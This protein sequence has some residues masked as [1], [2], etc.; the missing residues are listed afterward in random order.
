MRKSLMLVLVLLA[1]GVWAQDV[2]KAWEGTMTVPTYAWHD[3][4][5][6]VF[7]PLESA[8]Y[9]PYSKQDVIA[10]TKTDRVYR[11]LFLE[12]EYLKV[13]CLPELGGRI[14]SVLDKTTNREMF[15]KNDEVKP[16]LIAMRGAWISG[17]IEWNPGPQGH[18]V[19][20]VSP[21]DATLESNPDGSQSL[22]VS[23]TEKMFRTQWSVRL[24][25]HPGKAFLDE[26]IRIFNPTD[27]THPYYFWNCTAFPNRP[28]TRFIYPMTLGTDHAGSTFYSWP[29][30]KDRDLSWLKNYP[31]MSSIFGYKCEFDFFGA[32]DVDLDQGLISYA[33]HYVLPGKK[34]WTWG[35]D[36][37]GV[38]SQMELSD[39]GREGAPY[40]EVQSGPLRTQA[41][42][43][44]LHPHKQVAWKEFWYPVHSLGDGFEF[45]TC[46]AAVQTH[47]DDAGMLEFRIIATGAYPNTA[48]VLSL[49]GKTVLEKTL[50]LSPLQP[51]VVTLPAAAKEK[52]KITL[53]TSDNETLL[54]Y[55]T[56]LDIPKV[57]APD[58]AE[59]PARSDGQP[60]AEEKFKGAWLLDSQS[61]RNGAR[62]AYEDV[63][64]IDP[65]HVD[66][67][68]ALATLDIECGD[69]TAA[70]DRL[71]LAVKRNP[72][73]GASWYLLGVARLQQGDATSA[74][75]HAYATG[76][77]LDNPLLGYDLVGRASMRMGDIA[78]A[79]EAFGKNAYISPKK[80][81]QC[82]N[83]YLAALYANQQSDIFD[84][85]MDPDPLNFTA[86]AL[87]ALRKQALPEFINDLK[88]NSGE[89]E[90]T[91]LET[92]CFLADLGLYTDVVK[93][94][95]AAC[96]DQGNLLDC[97]PMPF[98]YLA[99]YSHLAGADP[100]AGR[101]LDQAAGMSVD[102]VFPARVEEKAMLQ[103]A[104]E[105]QPKNARAHLLLGYVTAGLNHLDDAL[106][107]WEKAAE[108]DASLH[109]AWRLLGMNAWKRANDLVKAEA[110]YRK[111]IAAQPAD[112]SLYGDLAVILTKLERRPDAIKLVETIPSGVTPRADTTAWLAQAYLDEK[113]L[114]DCIDL[115]RRVRFSNREGGTLPHDVYVQALTVRG[116]QRFEAKQYEGALEDFQAS[117]TYPENLAVGAKYKLVDAETRYWIGKTLLALNRP[118]EARAAFNEGASQI[119]SKDPACDFI[120][121]SAAQDEHVQ[122][123]KTALEVLDNAK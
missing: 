28:G 104:V 39:A 22:L 75:K 68:C 103:Y 6:P 23:N 50:D 41:E 46:D 10:K 32:Y 87:N 63:L 92:A 101:Y 74:L 43:G 12:N 61:N 82:R 33:N 36:D 118:G 121:I 113:R 96:V 79:V 26:S 114:D 110:Y 16:A 115:L 100:D 54:E 102:G 60:T 86:K 105:T 29:I 117:I 93:L 44:M 42:Y 72:D 108:L 49:G 25:L 53:R 120:A 94:L 27:G 3:D 38:V 76:R 109:T 85:A 48:C 31:T 77:T 111:A 35:T 91:L 107:L 15:H 112:Q 37:F 71:Q 64:A 56:P 122:R 62:K 47:R 7:E 45:A 11:T 4:P 18:T 20:V 58:L 30:N 14:F 17:G 95:S 67:L 21:V 34:A 84:A 2:V 90:F 99:Y 9:Y 70:E 123:C 57:E 98:Y 52:V 81:A 24:T 97:G 88:K 69:Y 73:S 116:K 83:H 1:G 89:K 5:N 106:P 80:D 65:M 55:E 8:I 78:G 19:T 13:V 119:T 40:I 51:A 66:A 59:K